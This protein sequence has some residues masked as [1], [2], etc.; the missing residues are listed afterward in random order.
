MKEYKLGKEFSTSDRV[1]PPIMKTKILW[2]IFLKSV[3]ACFNTESLHNTPKWV[4]DI[5]WA[6]AES[7]IT[8]STIIQDKEKIDCWIYMD[9]YVTNHELS[10]SMG[11]EGK[12]KKKSCLI[13]GP[14]TSIIRI[15]RPSPICSA[16]WSH[17]VCRGWICSFRWSFST[18]CRATI[19]GFWGCRTRFIHTWVLT[20]R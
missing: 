20:L 16:S 15:V 8:N 12:K 10:L 11:G 19:W 1:A 7:P 13:C 2:P 14:W 17:G 18:S 9:I 4:R 6:A 5:T 3:A